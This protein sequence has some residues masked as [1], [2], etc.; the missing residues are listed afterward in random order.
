M[1]NSNFKRPNNLLCH[2]PESGDEVLAAIY[3]YQ[4]D[5]S[6]KTILEKFNFSFSFKTVFLTDVEK[7][8]K[9]SNTNKESHSS[10][11]PTKKFYSSSFPSILT[12]D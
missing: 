5:P 1:P 2:T 9:S 12:L 10:D 7:E 6:I 4:N 11:M 8:M 3:K